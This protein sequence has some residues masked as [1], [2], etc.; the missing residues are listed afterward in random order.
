MTAR[1][2]SLQRPDQQAADEQP[3]DERRRDPHQHRQQQHQPVERCDSLLRDADAGDQIAI[4]DRPFD[5]REAE[6]SV[7]PVGSIRRKLASR[8]R[9]GSS[10]LDRPPGCCGRV[11]Q[12][13]P[14]ATRGRHSADRRRPGSRSHRRLATIRTR[15]SPGATSGMRTGV[16]RRRRSSSTGLAVGRL[17]LEAVAIAGAMASE[18]AG[19][20]AGARR[21][22]AASAPLAAISQCQRIARDQAFDAPALPRGLVLGCGPVKRG[23]GFADARCRRASVRAIP[24]GSRTAVRIRSS[25]AR[26]RKPRESFGEAHPAAS[27]GFG[28]SSAELADEVE[29]IVGNG[30][31]QRIVVDRAQG[32]AEVRRALLARILVG[33][34]RLL[35]AL[36]MLRLRPTRFASWHSTS[37]PPS[38]GSSR[39][40]YKSL[41]AAQRPRTLDAQFSNTRRARH[42]ASWYQ[43]CELARLQ[44]RKPNGRSFVPVVIHISGGGRGASGANGPSRVATNRRAA[45]DGANSLIRRR[46]HHLCRLA[47]NLLRT[48][49]SSAAMRAR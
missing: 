34:L 3:G 41:F 49:H 22:A 4:A 48:C 27:L 47:R 6:H 35:R 14:Q 32:T 44:R 46:A 19:A 45:K 33:R 28:R 7:R 21:P 39:A 9:A 31:A 43:L 29:E 16:G 10:E 1:L 17:E 38:R 40:S 30:F 24:I 11:A 8:R 37:R 42:C 25:F 12:L 36:S 15:M 13:L 26:G 5:D 20:I 23:I 18:L 2:Q